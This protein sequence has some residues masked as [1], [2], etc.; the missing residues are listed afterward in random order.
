[1]VVDISRGPPELTYRI[2]NHCCDS[3]LPPVL[4][5]LDGVACKRE[6]GKRLVEFLESYARA[7]V[8]GHQGHFS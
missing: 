5:D 3:Q 4:T 2:P 7:L 8:I 6:S 1:M